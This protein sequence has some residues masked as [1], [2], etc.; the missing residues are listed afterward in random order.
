MPRKDYKLTVQAYDRDFFKSNDM[1]GEASINI[2]NLLLDCSLVK[3]PLQLNKTYYKEVLE[4][5]N[6]QRLSFDTDPSR[7]WLEMR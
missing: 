6:F 4:K 3:K 2:K 7:F 5:N 1:I